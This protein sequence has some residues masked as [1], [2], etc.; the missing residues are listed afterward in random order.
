MRIYFMQAK[1]EKSQNQKKQK[2]HNR[3]LFMQANYE[4]IFLFF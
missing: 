4:I 1:N 2:K 3:D